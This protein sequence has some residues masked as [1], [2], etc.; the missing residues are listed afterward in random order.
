[1][2]PT[3][4]QDD[5]AVDTPDGGS[6]PVQPDPNRPPEAPAEP[7]DESDEAWMRRFIEENIHLASP[8]V[9]RPRP[10]RPSPGTARDRSGKCPTI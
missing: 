6:A 4:P 5:T 1:M 9:V 8:P 10:R 7:E 3:D 2:I